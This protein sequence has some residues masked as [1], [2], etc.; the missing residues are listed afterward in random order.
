M[1]STKQALLPQPAQ[2]QRAPEA[3]AK[4]YNESRRL[5]KQSRRIG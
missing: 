1:L 4:F 5:K 3:L 2:L